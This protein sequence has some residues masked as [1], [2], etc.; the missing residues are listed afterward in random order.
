MN[1]RPYRYIG[2]EDI[3]R[4]TVGNTERFCVRQAADVLRCLARLEPAAAC[5][6]YVPTTYVIDPQ[7]QLWLADRRSEHVACAAGAKG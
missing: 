7:G 5:R 2:P 4:R 6:S 3:R 1:H